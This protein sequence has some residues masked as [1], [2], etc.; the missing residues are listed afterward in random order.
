MPGPSSS[1]KERRET[2]N[3]RMLH[4]GCQSSAWCFEEERQM[5]F[6]VSN[7][8]LGVRKSTLGGSKG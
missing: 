8:P 4:E 7:R 5:G 3:I 6:S 1:I 2:R